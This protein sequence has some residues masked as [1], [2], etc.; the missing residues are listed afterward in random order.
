MASSKFEWKPLA[1]KKL[2][3]PSQIPVIDDH[4]AVSRT[5]CGCNRQ[6][7]LAEQYLEDET[8]GRSG[9]SPL[10]QCLRILVCAASAYGFEPEGLDLSQCEGHWS[11]L[12]QDI[13]GAD[14]WIKVVKYK[15][16][17]FFSYHISEKDKEH[18]QDDLPPCIFSENVIDKPNILIGGKFHRWFLRLKYGACR[19][20]FVSFLA[21]VLIGIKKG[22]PRAS[23]DGLF[24]A[25]LETFEKLTKVPAY[26]WPEDETRDEFLGSLD[27]AIDRVVD[28]V[29]SH[30]R[31]TKKQLMK[32]NFPSTSANYIRSRSEHG[33][34]AEILNELANSRFDVPI[35]LVREGWKRTFDEVKMD[36]ELKKVL[37]WDAEGVAE[38]ERQQEIAFWRMLLAARAE[39]NIVDTVA[40]PEALKIRVITKGSPRRAYVLKPLQKFL[41]THLRKH[42]VFSLIGETVTPELI[43]DRIGRLLP[44]EK[45]LSG[46][47]KDATD[48]LFSRFSE[49]AANRIL[50]HIFSDWPDDEE[51]L[52]FISIYS[53]LFLE[54]L[55]RHSVQRPKREL[56]GDDEFL[57]QRNGQLM[58]SITSFPILCIV[59]AAIC[60]TAMEYDKNRK[61]SLKKIRLIVNG[62]DCLFPCGERGLSMW[63][64]V[65][66][67]YGMKPSVGK[68]Y[69]NGRYLNINSTSYSY[70]PDRPQGAVVETLQGMNI[71]SMVNP[72]E[73]VKFINFGLLLMKKRS[74]GAK[75]VEDIFS[76]HG[77][78]AANSR[79][80]MNSCPEFCKS[81]VYQCYL[82]R[83]DRFVKH[84]KLP[85][86]PWFIPQKWGGMGLVPGGGYG[87]SEREEW[88]HR[89]V[90]QMKMDGKKFAI[91]R[92]DV[93]W[94][95]HQTIEKSIENELSLN[96]TTP[97]EH[98]F[99][100]EMSED[101]TDYSRL[102]GH[103]VFKTMLD[104]RF[105]RDLV[106]KSK[107]NLAKSTM[108]FLFRNAKVW[109]KYEKIGKLPSPMNPWKE[110]APNL[111]PAL[112]SGEWSNGETLEWNTVFRREQN[113]I[114]NTI[115]E[116]L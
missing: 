107:E 10:M 5:S 32:M 1:N 108:H 77:S 45:F 25:Q 67:Q 76:K 71:R 66:G 31:V 82:K 56:E 110:D 38:S 80:L 94:T 36:W 6:L 85:S 79:D 37:M 89:I 92:K 70:D 43:F 21:T 93:L 113:S 91:P 116:S 20:C 86:V 114:L 72:Y 41:H 24:S 16:S 23:E 13:K 54:S 7:R 51:S 63:K 29:F 75:G 40:L 87:T 64:W 74:G 50:S 14:P 60:R 97:V 95:C 27:T 44:G 22:C 57:P 83:F 30:V 11:Q 52:N 69:Y 98:D 65:C 73:H 9:Y 39:D 35:P 106:Y 3:N 47:Y 105:N 2:E 84:H 81:S 34:V 62:D 17:A 101:D 109:R 61:I 12:E 99:A 104:A 42:R 55:T 115:M 49:R 78:F 103:V 8:S 15:L 112:L 46:D 19:S 96:E 18:I 111:Y 100:P 28:E 26:P 53:S 90:H 68:F 4:V 102:Y 88:N 33:G 48:G 58:G 59:N